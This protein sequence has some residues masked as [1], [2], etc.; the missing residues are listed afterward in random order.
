MVLEKG[1][2]SGKVENCYIRFNTISDPAVLEIFSPKISDEDRWKLRDN[3]NKPY[4]IGKEWIDTGLRLFYKGLSPERAIKTAQPL[5]EKIAAYFFKKYPD[6][7]FLCYKHYPCG[8]SARV[9]F[10]HINETI[11][12]KYCEDFRVDF[13]KNY[14]NVVFSETGNC[15]KVYISSYEAGTLEYKDGVLEMHRWENED[16]A[17]SVSYLSRHYTQRLLDGVVDGADIKA[18]MIGIIRSSIA[19]AAIEAED[20]RLFETALNLLENIPEKYP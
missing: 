13:S 5:I 11:I 1:I 3:F 4:I 8:Q 14:C 2:L 17:Q 10:L 16:E 18:N 20:R 19:E 9:I 12:L 15:E 6:D 7:K